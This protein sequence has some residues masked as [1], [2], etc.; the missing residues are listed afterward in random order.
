MAEVDSQVRLVLDVMVASYLPSSYLSARLS[1]LILA[2]ILSL[3]ISMA[4]A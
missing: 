1:Y 3:T 4:V 2:L